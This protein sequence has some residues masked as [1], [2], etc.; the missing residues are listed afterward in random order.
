MKKKIVS[1]LAFGVIVLGTAGLAQ[2]LTMSDVGAIDNLL[3]GTELGNSGDEN[4]INWINTVLD[5]NYTVDDYLKYDTDDG[6]GWIQLADDNSVYAHSL[7][8]EPAY[9]L[10]KTG[11]L[12]VSEFD[13][14]LYENLAGLNWGVIDLLDQIGADVLE[15]KNIGKLSH[16][17]EFDT[18]PV[19]EPATMLL[20]GTG[21]AGLA[22][23]SRR[24]SKKS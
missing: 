12:K 6:T 8:S 16:V 14:F 21:I 23:I 20:F 18:S 4:E 5:T 13:T 11:N 19:P 3:A 15:I 24:K 9:F 2:A 7:S 22:G 1:C 10:I 17:G